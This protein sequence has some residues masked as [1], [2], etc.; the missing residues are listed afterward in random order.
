MMPLIVSGVPGMKE[1]TISASTIPSSIQV[2]RKSSTFVLPRLV[3]GALS[4]RNRYIMIGTVATAPS[5]TA[6]KI[7]GRPFIQKKSRNVM[8]A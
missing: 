8:F 6:K 5:S 4:F 3:T 7:P 1:A 2:G